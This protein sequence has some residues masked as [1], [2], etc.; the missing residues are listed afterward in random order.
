MSETA[1]ST[2]DITAQ[3][4]S[5]S[6]PNSAGG[7]QKWIIK[8]ASNWRNI[9]GKRVEVKMIFHAASSLVL[10]FFYISCPFVRVY[11]WWSTSS[12]WWEAKTKRKFY[13]MS[14]NS[15]KNRNKAGYCMDH[16]SKIE[17]PPWQQLVSQ[18]KFRLFPILAWICIRVSIRTW[19]FLSLLQEPPECWFAFEILF[20]KLLQT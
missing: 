15:R 12:R 2:A 1:T 6:A 13:W 9:A 4:A 11:F 19:L 16:F 10:S 18:G 17:C 8:I 20:L 7:S 3:V 5:S 14:L